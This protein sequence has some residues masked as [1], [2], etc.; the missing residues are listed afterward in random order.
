MPLQRSALRPTLG[1]LGTTYPHGNTGTTE[2]IDLANGNYHTATLDAN[3]TFTFTGATSG[4]ECAF[5]LALT[6]DATGSRTVTWPGSVTW[7]GASAPTLATS[8]A[9][10]DLLVF[11]TI[12]G[13]TS[14]LGFHATEAASAGVATDAIWDAPGDLAVGSGANTAARLAIGATNG[15]AVQRVSGA[16]AW[17]LPPGYEYDYVQITSPV[18]ITATTEAGANTVVTANAVTFDGSTAVIIEFFTPD[19]YSDNLASVD[20]YFYLYDGAGSIGLIYAMRSETTN[21]AFQGVYAR[22][23]LTPS[24]ASHTY[25]IRARLSSAG[26]GNV[27]A[28]SGGAGASL[29]AFIR[30]TKV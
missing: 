16:V 23:R 3:C 25:S 14:W 8:A 4:K 18:A 29:P 19:A 22:H 21:R 1:G 26:D 28:G 11:Y 15:M 2:T 12:D 10:L 9:A 17:A 13:G 30:I 5:T 24:A 27:D 7:P 6:Q 20:L